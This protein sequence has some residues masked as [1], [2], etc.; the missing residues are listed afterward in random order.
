MT[1]LHMKATTL[2]RN[3]ASFCVGNVSLGHLWEHLKWAH[4]L[5]FILL[6]SYSCS[7]AIPSLS[8]PLISHTPV[9]PALFLIHRQSPPPL[10]SLVTA[11]F[12]SLCLSGKLCLPCHSPCRLVL[13]GFYTDSGVGFE[14]GLSTWFAVSPH[15]AQFIQVAHWQCTTPIHTPSHP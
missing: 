4:F 3:S 8:Y 2:M 11:L 5:W 9:F 10:P 1:Q 7:S 14:G 15:N 6:T 13:C 12:P